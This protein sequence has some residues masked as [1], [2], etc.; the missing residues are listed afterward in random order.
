[1]AKPQSLK[2]QLQQ[3]DTG[4]VIITNQAR[5]GV[6][7]AAKRAGVTV[8][9]RNVSTGIEITVGPRIVKAP[10]P[11]LSQFDS[12]LKIVQEWTTDTRLKLFEHFELC[13][14]MN[15]GE[16]VCPEETITSAAIDSPSQ[17]GSMTDVFAFIAAA[18]SK[19]GIAQ[20]IEAP[21]EAVTDQWCFTS[22]K[23]QYADDCYVYRQQYLVSN[24]KR[25]R[26][27]R[28]DE[29]DHDYLIE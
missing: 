10:E 25:R 9:T 17:S 1:M 8:S 3:A 21:Q 11:K 2:H 13:C 23:P 20:P 19:K 6:Y 15:R 16:C 22:E 4:A 12:V 28:V 26:S 18:Q 24:P 27:V 14:G 5:T 7:V 29:D